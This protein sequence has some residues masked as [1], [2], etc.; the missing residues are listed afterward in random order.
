MPGLPQISSTFQVDHIWV[1]VIG[2]DSV[3]PRQAS[4]LQRGQRWID[5][6]VLRIW[7]SACTPFLQAAPVPLTLAPQ[8]G[9]A[10]PGMAALMGSFGQL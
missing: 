10:L 8:G 5:E 2:R 1:S 9:N 3:L 4:L 7:S 6:G